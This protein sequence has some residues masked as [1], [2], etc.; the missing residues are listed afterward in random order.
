LYNFAYYLKKRFAL[1]PGQLEPVSAA[2]LADH[3]RA[4]RNARG[5][6]RASVDWLVGAGFRAW[7]P[8][9]A[10][11]VAKRF[12][13]S[14]EWARK[15]TRI[16]R[17]RFADPNDIALFRIESAD[18][19]DHWMRRY[20]AAGVSK[21]INP[22]N[23][24][25]DCVL[26]DKVAFA[27]RCAEHGIAHPALLATIDGG[28]PT[29]IA[30]PA[31][32]EIV[33]KP[34]VGEGGSGVQVLDVPD[35]ARA[36]NAAFAAFL[37]PHAK[38]LR[39]TWLVQQRLTNHPDMADIAIN[40]LATVRLT[41]VFNEHGEPEVVTSVLRFPS[42][43]E[44]RVDNIKAGGLMAPIDPVT[45]TLGAAC[46]GR[47]VEEFE[48]HPISNAAVAGRVLPNWNE[49]VSL[50]KRAH[51]EAF[52]EYTLV[53]WDVALTADGPVILE[54]NG[55]PCLIVAQRAPRKGLGATR[56]GELLRYH[57][58]RAHGPEANH[59]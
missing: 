27:R 19:L 42:K 13:L 9:R 37:A 57:L 7:V 3:Y 24:R 48:R 59:G 26:A 47:G 44:S 50:G 31:I 39:G 17:A 15:A 38:G 41:T 40:A 29:V 33:L 30:V 52:P 46:R 5:P 16:G 23:W 18:E 34:N 53:G 6:F 28:V 56:F 45:G 14:R 32:S 22:H 1:Y 25:P 49:A 36:D 54:G 43:S 21:I 2:F 4:R 20:E 35:A 55:K 10:K 8:F 11:K 12:G 51:R 58:E